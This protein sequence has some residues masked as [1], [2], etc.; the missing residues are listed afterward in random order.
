MDPALAVLSGQEPKGEPLRN[1]AEPAAGFD[2]PLGEDAVAMPPD[3]DSR[4]RAAE[5]PASG[6]SGTGD[7]EPGA[8]FKAGTATKRGRRVRR[9]AERDA[10]GRDGVR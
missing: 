3:D 6:G 4:W 7:G 10:R 5:G 1:P 9:G 2:V 8:R